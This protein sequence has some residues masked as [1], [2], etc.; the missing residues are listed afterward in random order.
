MADEQTV[1]YSTGQQSDESLETGYV[2]ADT[3][4][5]T[6]NN[7]MPV[8]A[9]QARDTADRMDSSSTINNA[10]KNASDNMFRVRPRRVPS[11]GKVQRVCEFCGKAFRSIESFRSHTR[12]HASRPLQQFP[13]STEPCPHTK[14]SATPRLMCEVCGHRGKDHAAF[15]L[16]MRTYHPSAVGIDNTAAPFQCHSC[17]EK[18]FELRAL[19][20]HSR[21][22]HA[23]SVTRL[24]TSWFR[25][26]QRPRNSGLLHCS[27]CYRYCRTQLMLEAHERVHTGIKPFCCKVC[28]RSFRQSVHLTTHQRTHSNE[29]P[30]PCLLCQKAYKNRVDLRRHCSTKH[31]IVLPVKRH[32]AVGGVDV[33]AA[34]V[35]A[36]DIGP[37]D[38]D[39]MIRKQETEIWNY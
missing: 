30:F 28:G 35:A 37:D 26:P 13:H 7:F 36:A 9:E 29:R 22:V 11:N 10:E 23:P 39:G 4:L 12:V 2:S 32:G 8:P 33:I 19:R 21:L 24:K 15:A 5:Q 18:F 38:E 31:G 6:V 25:R 34:A 3:V 16:H 14:W 27:Y 1:N 17:D 20:H